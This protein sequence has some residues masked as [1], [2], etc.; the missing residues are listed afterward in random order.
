MKAQM[1]RWKEEYDYILVD[2][3]P[4]GEMSDGLAISELVSGYLFVL[5]AGMNDVRAIR[6]IS[7]MIESRGSGVLGYILTDVEDEYYRLS[8]YYMSDAGKSPYHNPVGD[9]ASSHSG[10]NSQ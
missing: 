4:M 2:L 3:P 9:A 1:N 7:A 10:T 6:E 5:R 8:S